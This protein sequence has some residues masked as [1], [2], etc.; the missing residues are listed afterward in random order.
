MTRLVKRICKIQ[1]V[2]GKPDIYVEKETLASLAICHI[3]TYILKQRCCDCRLPQREYKEPLW[4]RWGVSSLE[5]KT[6]P[7]WKSGL[8]I[9][10]GLDALAELSD[11]SDLGAKY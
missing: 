1:S 10:S 3:H 8:D 4:A 5:F 2:A 7:E 11:W 6:K 9:S